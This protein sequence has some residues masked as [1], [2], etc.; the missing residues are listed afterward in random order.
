MCVPCAEQLLFSAEPRNSPTF[1][2][3]SKYVLSTKVP[4]KLTSMNFEA[5]TVRQPAVP[6]GGDGHQQMPGGGPT[7]PGQD[8]WQMPADWHQ[9]QGNQSA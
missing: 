4:I 5:L 9:Y 3:D 6:L 2:T 8:G 1:A 7:M